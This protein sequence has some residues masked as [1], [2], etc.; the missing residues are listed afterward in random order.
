MDL[1]FRITKEDKK[2]VI[3]YLLTPDVQKEL[4]RYKDTRRRFALVDMVHDD[5][6]ITISKSFARSLLISNIEKINLLDGT[7]EYNCIKRNPLEI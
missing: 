7:Y 2:R 6:G 5:L 1:R 4:E 3:D